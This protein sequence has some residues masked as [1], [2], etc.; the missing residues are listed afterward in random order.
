[1]AIFPTPEQ[2]EEIV[3]R[4]IQVERE[5][6]R[7]VSRSLSAI[8]VALSEWDA[9]KNKPDGLGPT[10]RYLRRSYDLLSEWERESVSG[11]QDAVSRFLRLKT[12]VALCRKLESERP[13]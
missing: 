12:Y 11:R 10:I 7:T 13:G 6:Q 2:M 9:A 4:A 8:E 1:M 3:S 5:T